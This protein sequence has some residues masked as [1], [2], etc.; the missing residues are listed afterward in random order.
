MV[1]SSQSSSSWE[2]TRD[3]V[4]VILAG[5]A[6]TRFWPA[7]TNDKPKQFLRF[8]GSR[9]LLQQSFDLVRDVVGAGRVVVLTSDAFVPLV[10]EQLPE[11]P[12][13]NIVGEPSRKDTAAALALAAL[14]VQQRF[15]DVV[16]AVLTSDHL[17]GPADAFQRTLLSAA[18]AAQRDPALYT[19]GIEPTFPAT[20]Y[21]YLERGEAVPH[22]DDIPHH[23]LVR[24][25]EK[26]PLARA[27]EYLASGRFLWNS[28]M[29][30]WA[31]RT[32]L[33]EFA[34]HL[35][36][37][38][39]V[40]RPAVARIDQPDFHDVLAAA[41]DKLQRISIDFAIMEKARSVRCVTA[42]FDWSDVGSFPALADHL[43]HDAYDNVH[44]GRVQT[45]DAARNL[46]FCDDDSEL[47]ALIGVSDLIVVR[48]GKRTLVVPRARAE[49][50]K[51]LVAQLPPSD[52]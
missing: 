8:F 1:E 30:V 36:A 31:T 26:P 45:I 42:R 13:G 7:S 29:F 32:I 14:V 15:G 40:L 37:H 43:P 51:A 50:I 10:R 38:V 52:T 25:V 18:R 16:M 22:D 9:S 34:Q 33:A 27:T 24:F 49:E 2:P 3:L 21:G 35:P 17:I 44:R 4:V 6:G 19:F 41:F 46:V 23:A 28:G 11:V 47:V 39:D 48:A 20:G 12:A 5:G